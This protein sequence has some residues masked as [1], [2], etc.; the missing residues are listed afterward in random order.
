VATKTPPP[1]TTER[2][3][4]PGDATL[5][6]EPPFGL[7]NRVPPVATVTEPS[8]AASEKT[9][10]PTNSSDQAAPSGLE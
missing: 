4:D 2:N 10:L 3:D 9:L 7:K 8:E 1:Q 6:H 5:D